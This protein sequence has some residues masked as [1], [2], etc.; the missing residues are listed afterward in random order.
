MVGQVGI[1][2]KRREVRG[3][4]LS[5]ILVTGHA[6]L[7]IEGATIIE[8]RTFPVLCDGHGRHGRK[9]GGGKAGGPESHG[10]HQRLQRFRKEMSCHV[11]DHQSRDCSGWVSR[12]AR[13][14]MSWSTT[15]S[16]RTG[17]YPRPE[18]NTE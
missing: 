3:N 8:Q 9:K 1:A 11:R 12:E 4:A 10:V 16:R 13:V 5:V 18:T 7:F 2:V 6:V 14:V 15:I 17:K